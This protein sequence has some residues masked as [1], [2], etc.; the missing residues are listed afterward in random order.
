MIVRRTV[1]VGLLT[2]LAVVIAGWFWGDWLAK[3]L[4]ALCAMYG[5]PGAIRT[6]AVGLS[7]R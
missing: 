7:H 4:R 1:T 5:S 3:C 6:F 2:G